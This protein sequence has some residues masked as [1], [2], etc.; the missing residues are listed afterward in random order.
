MTY[1]VTEEEPS[2]HF[3]T[4][5]EGGPDAAFGG[6]WTYGV[7]LAP[8]NGTKVTVAET[9]WVANPVFRVMLKLGG[10]HATL[11]SYL[12]ALGTRFGQQVTPVH[13]E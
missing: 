5:I 13:V 10:P 1:K 7:E 6:S 11:D 12:R 3:T 4:E 8:N 9:G 2:Q